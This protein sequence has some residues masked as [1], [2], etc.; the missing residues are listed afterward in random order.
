MPFSITAAARRIWLH[1]QR[2]DTRS[3]FGE[4]AQAVADAYHKLLGHQQFTG[5][6]G[7][8]FG[9]EG[10]GCIYWHMVAKL[11]LAVQERVFEALDRQA[12]ALDALKAHYYRVRDGLGYRKTA[13][14]FGAFPADPYSHT[15]GEGGAQRQVRRRAGGQVSVEFE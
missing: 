14:A 4:G 6:S 8:M 9:F 1:A 13:A 10:L 15:P 7:T 12:P 2:L 11:L 3:P 5:R